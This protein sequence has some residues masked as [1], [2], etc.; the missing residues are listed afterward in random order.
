[1]GA[2]FARTR[3]IVALAGFLLLLS[4]AFGAVLLQTWPPPPAPAGSAAAAQEHATRVR[5]L[6]WRL[7]LLRDVRLFFVVTAAGGLG[8]LVHVLRSLYEYVGNQGLKRRWLLMYVLEPCIGSMMALIV[9]FVLRGGLT[10]TTASSNDINPY[11]V[12]A[13]AALVG[14]FARE[15]VDKMRRVFETV[16]TTAEKTADRMPTSGDR[17]SDPGPDR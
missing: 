7:G 14:M 4:C 17:P 9:Y 10:T 11:G 16:F 1:M 2:R 13:L 12:A 6:F 8:A 5:I 3:D 15:A